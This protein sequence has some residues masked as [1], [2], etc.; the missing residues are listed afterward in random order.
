MTD[1]IH[2]S[3]ND[4]PHLVAELDPDGNT[5]FTHYGEQVSVLELAAGTRNRLDWKCLAVS[6]TP[7]GH[8]WKST[9]NSRTTKGSGCPACAN[10]TINNQDGRNSMAQTHPELA[11][12]YQ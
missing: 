9:G 6:D 3:W 11:S 7:C 5:G 12:E 2:P 10:L 8:T 4:Y 1:K